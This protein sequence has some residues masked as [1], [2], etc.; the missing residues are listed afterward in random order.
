MGGSEPTEGRGGRRAGRQ[1][2]NALL[3]IIARLDAACS[4]ASA[5]QNSTTSASSG[6]MSC[7]GSSTAWRQSAQL[8]FPL[9]HT[10]ACAPL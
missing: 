8:L 2:E 6:S 3:A 7:V 4:Q 1:T 5:A 10:T 9:S